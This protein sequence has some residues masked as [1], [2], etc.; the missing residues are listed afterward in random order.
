MRSGILASL[1]LVAPIAAAQSFTPVRELK[2]LAPEEIAKLHTLEEL[3][4]LPGGDWRFHAGDLPHGESLSLDD[5]AWKVVPTPAEHHA[6][7]AP[8]D[9]VW[10]R[11]MIEIPRTLH[12]YDLTGSRLWFQF[13]AD[14]NGPMP[15]IIYFN[16]RRVAIGDDLEPVVLEDEV[17][18]GDKILIAVK[19]LRTVDEKSFRG[20]LFR[21][22]PPAA[23]KRPNPND[24]RMQIVTAANMLPVL[25][26]PRPDLLPV[27]HQALAAIDFKALEAE[28]QQ[29]FDASLRT[30]QT[31]L[32]TLS[33]AMHTA[34]VDLV[35]NAHIDAAWLWP[36][37]E[38]VDAVKRTF[39]T[40]LQLMNE[41]PEYSFSQSA[42][43]YSEWMADKYPDLNDQIKQ[44]VK[45]G[46][47]EIVGGMWIEPD[48]NLPGGE[49]EVRQLLVGQRIFK[50]LYGVTARIG[51]N[52]DSFG[53]NWQLPQI[54][55]RSGLDYFVTQKMHWNDTNQLPLRLFW[56]QSPDGS[57]VLTYFPTDYAW[58]NVNPTRLSADYAESSQRNPGTA[59]HLD[60]YGVGD[61]GGGPTRDMLDAA[62]HWMALSKQPTALPNF[63]FT[64]AQQYF[65]DV[66]TH[67]SKNSPVLNYDNI[68]SYKPAAPDAN[69]NLSIPTW[70]DELYFEYH[71]GIYTTQAKHKAFMRQSEEQTLDAEK[72]AS[73]AWLYGQ[74][75]PAD[76]LTENWKKITF[77]QFHDLAAGSGVATIYRDAAKDY[78]EV[79]N[80][81]A[82]I[83][84]QS[85]EDI[86]TQVNTETGAGKPVLVFNPLPWQRSEAVKVDVELADPTAKVAL[87]DH[88]G[89]L[90]ESQAEGKS[91]IAFVSVPALGYAVLS[92]SP[93]CKTSKSGMHGEG[94]C[95]G[96]GSSSDTSVHETADAFALQND[97]VSFSV[98]KASGCIS[99]MTQ[100]ILSS[101]SSN[102]EWL[103]AN[104]CGNQLQAFADNPKQY[105]AWNIDPGT[106]DKA[107]TILDK[108][109]SVK[110]V[111]DGPLRKTIRVERTYNKS[112]I[113]QDISLDAG[114]DTV[115]IDTTIDWHEKHVLLKAAFPLAATAPK[116]TYEIPF[117]SIQRP[118][119]RDNSYQKAQFEVP[120]LQWADLGDAKQG[121][122]IL[123]D[124]KYGYD[125]V[126]N[127]LRLTL[128]RAPTWPDADADQGLQHFRY[129]IYPHAGDWHISDTVRRAYDLNQPL[130]AAQTFAHSGALPAEHSFVRIDEP[131]V[132]LTAVKKAENEDAL[133][134]RMYESEGKATNMTLHIP[135]GAVAA[136]ETNLMEKPEGSVLPLKDDTITVAIKPYE[137]LT[138][139]A[140]YPKQEPKK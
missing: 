63:R 83:N 126:G 139:E 42:A 35:G 28:D 26:K 125:A 41:Y 79:L 111:V 130:I 131:N 100:H 12:G 10:Y 75:Y 112:H 95:V 132:I 120:A 92:A 113:T 53:Y 66:Q 46:R 24:L 93:S 89:K 19:L 73:F 68:L 140:V 27:V 138:V 36:A 88:A 65:D 121:V 82:L 31:A 44:R 62:E 9:A 48:L 102:T 81:D 69:G 55:K 105:D 49:S 57:K 37:S 114:A 17:K 2:N 16:G 103:A 133:I 21:I 135:K 116:A 106:L 137:I 47:W 8:T 25:P 108:A 30:A 29:G 123:N 70:N 39:S 87:R 80:Q 40:A 11:Q 3:S 54:Y 98:N 128:L 84:N 61:H 34:T 59:E 117:G 51:W 110:L 134:F 5:S 136:T 56:W 85:L 64:T 7:K 1:L 60:L 122:S 104:V 96:G 4:V 18:P 67:L 118:T 119:T 94:A 52:P 23:S 38:T 101:H 77:N 129:A 127:V 115:V 22:D 90:V 33:P 72:L 15:E 13:Q 109:D 20:V 74:K 86:A 50:D 91:A 78:K 71:R 97:H 76:E 32:S 45:E 99:T 58:T 6:T 43:Q 14:A 124:S 107:P